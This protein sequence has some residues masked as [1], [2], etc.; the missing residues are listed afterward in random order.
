MLRR[1]SK[2]FGNKDKSKDKANGQKGKNVLNG[3]NGVNGANVVNGVNGT[4]KDTDVGKATKPLNSNNEKPDHE[5]NRQEV[6]SSFAAFAHLVHAAQRPM[7]NQTGDGTYVEEN[8]EHSSIWSDMRA[9]GFKDAKTLGEVL[10]NTASGDDVDDKGM[11]MERAIQVCNV[12]SIRR[13]L[14]TIGSV[15]A[16]LCVA[17]EFQDTF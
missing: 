7:P 15:K 17:T 8:A 11:L 5:A 13:A 4:T 16:C 10:K 1:L 6:E 9:L 14:L 3:V 12:T 2:Q